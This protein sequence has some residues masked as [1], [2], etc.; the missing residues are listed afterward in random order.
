MNEKTLV[1]SDLLVS[2]C[3]QGGIDRVSQQ[4]HDQNG[5]RLQAANGL[6]GNS[7]ITTEYTPTSVITVIKSRETLRLFEGLQYALIVILWIS[8]SYMDCCWA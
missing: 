4:S 7:P 6:K 1:V 3:L 8:I 2:A 5:G